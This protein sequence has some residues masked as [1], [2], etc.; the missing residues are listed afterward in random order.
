MDYL[1][2][3]FP[4]LEHLPFLHD[5]YRTYYSPYS[6]YLAPVR[7][8][9][10]F[11]HRHMGPYIYPYYSY[12]RP[13]YN[14]TSSTLNSA[15]NE[16]PSLSTLALLALLLLF[17]LKALDMLRR[18]V[19]YWFG[20]AMRMG[21]WGAVAIVG[22]Y[23]WQRGVEGS[24]EDLGVL[25]EWAM[26]MW[27]EQSQHAQGYQGGARKGHKGARKGAGKAP[28]GRTRGSGW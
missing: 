12:L 2:A 4:Q 15:L 28:R 22:V 17:S 10:Y 14:L 23:V 5:L 13:L 9:A 6:R 11:A 16:T 8:Y 1:Q 27:E 19:M 7:R 18:T 24:A 25:W 21:M 26:Q 3:Y 20:F